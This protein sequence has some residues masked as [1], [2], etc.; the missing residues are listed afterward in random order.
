[1]GNCSANAPWRRSPASVAFEKLKK[2]NWTFTFIGTD[3]LDV[4]N[5]ACCMG[6]D[7][8]LQFA[9]DEEDTRKMFKQECC[10]RIRFN[11]VLAEKGEME[12]GTYF[13]F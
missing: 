1:M 3:N 2:Q 10:S 12:K 7:N 6:I 13:D 4:E 9:E 8:H 11:N 5:M